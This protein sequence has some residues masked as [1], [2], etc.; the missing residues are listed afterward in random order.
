[1][2]KLLFVTAIGLLSF[3]KSYSQ[4]TKKVVFKVP[5]DSKE[6]SILLEKYMSSYPNNTQLSIALIDDKNITYIGVIRKNDVLE[7]ISNEEKS[8]EIGSITK[9]FTSVLLAS[10][11]SQGNMS[12]DDP[13]KS[14][15]PFT[16]KDNG[17][18][19]P[20][21]TLKMLANHTS[22]LPRVP[23]NLLEDLKKY[24]EDNPYRDYDSVRLN[25]YLK[26]QMKLDTIPGVTVSYSNLGTGLL[27]YII[28][29]N[30]KQTF[31]DLLQQY[32]FKPLKMNNSS[33]IVDERTIV[34]GQD[35][36][37]NEITNWD[38]N[39]LSG[40]GS[41]K[42]TAKDM[43]KFAIKN[44]EGGTY[45]DLVQEPTFK[46]NE[47]RKMG[48]G[49]NI[50]D[51]EEENIHVYSHNGGTGG[52]RSNMIVSR[53]NKIGVIILSNVSAYSEPAESID[54]LSRELMGI[55]RTK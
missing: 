4:D 36:N 44:I 14:Y 17:R 35:L 53:K 39:V 26:N 45:Y 50:T 19:G 21:I 11:V 55:L 22:G 38:L 10:Q 12:L 37:G 30:S 7:T 47:W 51:I 24:K 8:F 33:T 46:I 15:L 2:K 49:W 18:E 54:Q 9:V 34:K 3:T 31:E 13:I 5:L 28:C 23:S 29:L 20:E 42:S 43:T 41:I 25:E 32:I 1:M 48:L 52:Y 6:I 16:R 40:A 27:G